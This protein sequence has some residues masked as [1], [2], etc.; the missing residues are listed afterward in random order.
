MS[1]SR[2]E[3]YD[4]SDPIWPEAR[5]EERQ[6]MLDL[7]ALEPQHIVCDVPAWC[8][9]LAEGAAKI[10]DA[11]H[12]ICVEPSPPFA[13]SISTR[14]TVHCCAQTA[15]PLPDASVDRLGSMVGLHH[16]PNKLV[17]LREATRVVRSGGRLAISEV[18]E[19]STVARFLDG[20]VNACTANGHRGA[21][22]R[23]GECAQ[24]LEDAGCGNIVERVHDLHWK[25][26]SVEVMARFC[27]GLLGMTKAT[28]MQV[29]D[30]IVDHFNVKMVGSAVWLPW[31]LIYVVGT[32]I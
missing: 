6:I 12:V 2:K 22:V 31:S 10:V 13:A 29:L 21:F 4:S 11:G 15:L 7:L 18:G 9:Y 8:G 25:F 19:G 32:K 26:D 1:Q 24:L 3:L 17:F 5:A 27:R 14:F 28:E 23:T 16:L 20:P 30:T